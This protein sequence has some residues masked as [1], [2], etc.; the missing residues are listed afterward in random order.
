[1]QLSA[2]A[3]WQETRFFLL[4]FFVF[5][6]FRTTAF[7][8]YHIPSESMLPTLTV[9]DRIVVNKFAYGYSRHSLPFS[10]GP[11]LKTTSGR[12]LYN[13]P[14]RGDIAVFKHPRTQK[15]LIKRIIALPGDTVELRNGRL[16]LNGEPMAAESYGTY[17]YKEHKGGIANV[18]HY[19]EALP[20]SSR[21]SVYDVLD[22]GGN[23]PG[24]WFSPR[25]I[26][27]GMIFVL[28]DNRDNSLD[29]RFEQAGVGLLPIE[30]LVGR[31]DYV[32]FSTNLSR[33]IEKDEK[34]PSRWFRGL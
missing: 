20:G 23:Y 16:I 17:Q 28:G 31:A 2:K 9:G 19:G 25:T 7:A 27:D 4:V 13:A 22:N 1:M 10:I 33:G 15:T 11:S 6:A 30:H 21:T 34:H 29:S 5:L 18:L 14:K 12:I 32:A 26:P 3:I 8:M 24:D